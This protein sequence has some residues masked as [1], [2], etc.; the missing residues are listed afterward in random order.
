[1]NAFFISALQQYGYPVLWLIVFVAA[2]GAPISGSLLLFAAGA[3][4]AFGDLNILILFPVAVSAA[5]MG[6]NLTY[7]IGR[8]VGTALLAWLERQKRFRWISPQALERGRIYFRRRAAWA[9]F[10]TRFFIVVLGGAIN[11]LAGLEQYPY[12]SFLFWDVSGQIL[13]AIIP[14]GLGYLFAESWEEVA[15]IFGATAGLFL[16]C[17]VALILSALFVR[18]IR[19]ARR[20]SAVKARAN[21]TLQLLDSNAGKSTGPLPIPD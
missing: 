3:F 9:I 2:A 8:R 21:E 6:D 20:I 11:L 17:L 13:G 12:R 19:Q 16:V 1:M 10:I 5:V 4:S 18:K 14:L 7:F 15:G